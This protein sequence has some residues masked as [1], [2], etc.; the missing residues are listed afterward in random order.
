MAVEFDKLINSFFPFA[1]YII[2]AGI[3]WL[4]WGNIKEWLCGL[5]LDPFKCGGETGEIGSGTGW[6]W[7]TDPGYKL[8]FPDNQ[9]SWDWAECKCANTGDVGYNIIP[10]EWGYS[11]QTFCSQNGFGNSVI[12]PLP[13]DLRW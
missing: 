11:C 9:T 2:G 4:Y 10:S 3:V 6:S 8:L 12:D 13:L 5:P 7:L 1:P